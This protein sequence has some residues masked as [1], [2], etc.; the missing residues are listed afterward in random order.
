VHRFE[1]TRRH[2]VIG[3]FVLLAATLGSL[4]F[5]GVQTIRARAEVAGLQHQATQQGQAI[6][7]MDKQ[8]NQLRTQIQ[9]VQTQNQ[10]IKQL[11]GV[12]SPAK[13]PSKVQKTSWTRP[14]ASTDI[15]GVRAQLDVLS[16]ASQATQKESDSIRTLTMRVLN[17]RHVQAMARAH[18]L[19]AIP[20][21]DPVAGA[22]VVGCFCYRSYPSAEFHQGVDLGAGYGEGVRASAAGTVV[23]AAYD[24]GFGEKIVIDHG[25]GY[26]TWYAH[27]ERMDVSEGQHVYKGES[28]GLVGATGFSTGPHLHYQVMHNG[29][30]VD[31]APYLYGVPA[32]VLASLP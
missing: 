22:A 11:I 17:M 2:I 19:A 26:Q 18:L 20:S 24:G 29:Q 7:Q 28:I 32:N 10:E 9:H 23:S 30:A 1:V 5:A 8:T 14:A 13:P 6:Q 16:K 4:G 27:L 15:D 25:N 3:A 21:I 12:R 31:P